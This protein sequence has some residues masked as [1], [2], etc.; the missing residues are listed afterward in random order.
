MTRH[1]HQIVTT[2]RL[3][4]ICTG[5]VLAFALS[6]SVDASIHGSTSNTITVHKAVA[7]PGVVLTPGEYVFEILNTGSTG[8]VVRVASRNGNTTRY[9]GLTMGIE[10]SDR[11]GAP[12]FVLGEAPAGEPQPIRAWFPDG[13]NRG[14]QLLYR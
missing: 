4:A 13:L 7:L 10:R 3:L 9:L 1:I 14:E 8:H 2:P 11:P 5:A 12:S 6:V